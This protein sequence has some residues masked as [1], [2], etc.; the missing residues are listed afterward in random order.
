M[1]LFNGNG[2]VKKAGVVLGVVTSLFVFSWKASDRI[3]CRIADAVAASEERVASSLG[4][5]QRQQDIRHW[6]QLRDMAKIELRRIDRALAENPGDLNLS[7]DREY[8]QKAH[9][10]G[11][12]ELYKILNE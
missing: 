10:K 3:D 6:V 9:D 4:K 1:K 7:A 5:F 8:W 2:M 12:E 11:T